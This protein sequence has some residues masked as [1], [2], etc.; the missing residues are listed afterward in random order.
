MVDDADGPSRPDSRSEMDDSLRAHQQWLADFEQARA[1]RARERDELLAA[2]RAAIARL[3]ERNEQLRRLLKRRALLL[4]VAG[5][6]AGIAL[7]WGASQTTGFWSLL[8]DALGTGLFVAATVSVSASVVAGYWKE[9]TDVSSEAIFDELRRMHGRL[10]EVSTAIESAATL[11]EP[12]R[13]FL[14]EQEAERRATANIR[15]KEQWELLQQ[16]KVMFPRTEAGRAQRA[17]P[18]AEDYTSEP[19][20][21][22]G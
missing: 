1:E 17:D 20:P 13:E 4:T 11:R 21:G 18:E 16:M 22:T 7:I 14:M 2:A 8:L 15:R 3:E 6:L 5:A 12:L 9:A 19:R 10:I